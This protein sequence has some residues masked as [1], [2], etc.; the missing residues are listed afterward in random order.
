MCTFAHQ[1]KI[2]KGG[3]PKKIV[4]HQIKY[5]KQLHLMDLNIP[6]VSMIISLCPLKIPVRHCVG[7]SKPFICWKNKN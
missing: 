6:L 7:N 1:M 5:E 3:K 4:I 2:N